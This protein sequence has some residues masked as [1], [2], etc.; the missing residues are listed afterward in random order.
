MSDEMTNEEKEFIKKVNVDKAIKK[1]TAAMVFIGIS[2]LTYVI[3]MIM[4][5]YDFGIIFEVLSLIFILVSRSYMKEYDEISAKKYNI[6]AIASIGWILIYDLLIFISLMES[7]L[8]LT[9][10]VYV[11]R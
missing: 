10:M 5:E 8:D 3:P 6:F 1:T 4:G 2:I 7:M 9:A 11:Y